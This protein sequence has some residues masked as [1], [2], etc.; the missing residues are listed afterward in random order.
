MG[1]VPN[2]VL[3]IIYGNIGGIDFYI[4]VMESL[5]FTTG[6]GEMTDQLLNN[7]AFVRWSC[8]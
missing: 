5:D 3:G 2:H 8:C 7:L 4:N 6:T 1:N